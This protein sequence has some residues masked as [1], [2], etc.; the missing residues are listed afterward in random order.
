ML[1]KNFP[2]EKSSATLSTLNSV[3]LFMFLF[4]S[5]HVIFSSES[6]VTDIT[7]EW[8]NSSVDKHVSIEMSSSCKSHGANVTG[9]RIP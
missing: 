5:Q 1:L 9:H 8:F 6:D 7:S 3:N 4:V 2:R